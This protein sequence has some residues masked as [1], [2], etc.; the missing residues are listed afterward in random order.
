MA[1]V[2]YG[3]GAKKGLHRPYDIPRCLGG[4]ERVHWRDTA[5]GCGGGTVAAHSPGHT[6]P[7]TACGMTR[8]QDQRH[9]RSAQD[10]RVLIGARFA[11]PVAKG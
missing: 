9:G 10:Q 7:A 6:R 1:C 3:E 11:L 5:L 2:L 8:G 4:T